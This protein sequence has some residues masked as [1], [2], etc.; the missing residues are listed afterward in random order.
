ME[1]TRKGHETPEIE[2]KRNDLEIPDDGKEA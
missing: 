2:R 1:R